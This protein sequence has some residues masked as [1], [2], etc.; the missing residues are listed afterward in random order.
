MTNVNNI[1]NTDKLTANQNSLIKSKSLINNFSSFLGE[2]KSLDEIF[3]NAADKY[4]V[5][6]NL[7]KSIGKAES[8][9]RETVVSRSGAVGIMQL[10]PATAAYLGV[11][12][13]YNAEQNIMGGAKYIKELLGKYNGDTSLALAAYNAGSGNVAKYGGIPP[14]Q[15]TQNYVKKVLNYM[16]TDIQ[17]G[18]MTTSNTTTPS[19]V[20]PNINYTTLK[21][22]SLIGTNTSLLTST[23]EESTEVLDNL[24]DLF[25]YDKYLEFLELFMKNMSKEESEKEKK[26]EQNNST[27]NALNYNI[28]I[29]NLLNQTKL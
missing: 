11:K 23:N 2:T 12:D 5:P 8:D 26:E 22:V 7:L 19:S 21:N 9:F 29:L 27:L 3:N 15:E 6:V 24:D 4:D 1:N 25:S 10:M 14:F 28:P 20:Y 13:S 17:T 18:V 16:K